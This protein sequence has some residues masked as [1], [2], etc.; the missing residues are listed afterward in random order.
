MTNLASFKSRPNRRRRRIPKLASMIERLEDKA[1]PGTFGLESWVAA[2][3]AVIPLVEAMGVDVPGITTTDVRSS[4]PTGWRFLSSNF[5][6]RSITAGRGFRSDICSSLLDSHFRD[7]ALAIN[8][9]ASHAAGTESTMSRS[10]RADIRSEIS[11]RDDLQGLSD[12]L[13][14]P[15]LPSALADLWMTGSFSLGQL[16]TAR[17]D[18]ALLR[19][20]SAGSDGETGSRQAIGSAAPAVPDMGLASSVLGTPLMNSDSFATSSGFAGGVAQQAPRSAASEPGG[21]CDG[22]TANPDLMDVPA[23]S[24][25]VAIDVLANDGL[26]DLAPYTLSIIVG[27]DFGSAWVDTTS[28]VIYY[29]PPSGSGSGEEKIEYT[30]SFV[31]QVTVNTGAFAQAQVQTP[32]RSSFYATREYSRG[33]DDPEENIYETAKLRVNLGF[34]RKASE[35]DITVSYTAT[36]T[37]N[38]SV[39]GLPEFQWSSENAPPFLHPAGVATLPPPNSTV[40]PNEAPGVQLSYTPPIGPPP[41]PPA[42]FGVGGRLEGG[43]VLRSDVGPGT[44]TGTAVVQQRYRSGQSQFYAPVRQE[45][46]WSVTIAT[47]TRGNAEAIIVFT[48]TELP[49]PNVWLPPNQPP[50]IP[51]PLRKGRHDLTTSGMGTIQTP[52]PEVPGLQRNP[53]NPS[54]PLNPPPDW[55]AEIPNPGL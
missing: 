2:G 9:S 35:N 47:S 16:A 45:I 36:A 52:Y 46:P 23:G 13:V 18:S 7:P 48:V 53:T 10:D 11:V 30:D 39:G 15:R 49:F 12:K 29:E 31:Y 4:A 28:N 1:P 8:L 41:P 32:T 25:A 44:Y 51:T 40:V 20:P 5:D 38:S 43:L 19:G 17:P 33:N 50:R 6:A 26:C 42:V 24:P 3:P 34:D 54:Q 55:N 14:D 37:T 27:P 21:S 22:P